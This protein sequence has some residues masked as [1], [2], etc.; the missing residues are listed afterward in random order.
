MQVL[1][2]FLRLNTLLPRD[3]VK[4][5]V[6]IGRVYNICCKSVETCLLPRRGFNNNLRKLRSEFERISFHIMFETYIYIYL[7]H[8]IYY[9][10][11]NFVMK[12]LYKYF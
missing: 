4:Y 12:Y 2:Q 11:S 5:V 7:F 6:Y 9:R 1:H 8:F 10:D 3:I